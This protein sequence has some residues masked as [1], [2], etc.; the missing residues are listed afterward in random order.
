M[1]TLQG[2]E[3]LKGCRPPEDP[4]VCLLAAHRPGL[5]SK[6]QTGSESRRKDRLPR[7]Q[8]V[9]P[10]GLWYVPRALMPGVSLAQLLSSP[11]D[12]HVEATQKVQSS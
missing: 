1:L 5:G 10:A 9:L 3:G 7:A 2:K 12:S 4:W 11:P 6:L 8:Q